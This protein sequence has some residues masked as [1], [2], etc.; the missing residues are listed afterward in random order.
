MRLELAGRIRE[1]VRMLERPGSSQLVRG[2]IELAGLRV[3]ARAERSMKP[4]SKR[5]RDGE[6]TPAA[7]DGVVKVE[8][9]DSVHLG[10]S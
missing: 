6:V 1:V 5:A 3:L 7:V 4:N 10:H 2:Y 9:A 8:A